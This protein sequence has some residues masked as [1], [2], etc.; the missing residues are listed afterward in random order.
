MKNGIPVKDVYSIKEVATITRL[1][2]STIRRWILTDHLMA[3][4]LGQK[5]WRINQADVERIINPKGN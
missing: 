4:R 2:P 1:A 3:H 5:F